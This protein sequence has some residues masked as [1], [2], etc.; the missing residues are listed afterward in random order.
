MKN[1]KQYRVLE[2]FFRGLRGEDISVKKLAE[3]YGVSEKSVSRS[4]GELKAFLADHREL[5]GNTEFEYSY[6]SKCYRLYMDEFLSAKE[7]FALLEVLIGTKSFSKL[8]LLAIVDKLKRF[9]A[10]DDRKKLTELVSKELY[11]YTEVK[12]DCDSVQDMLW[13]LINCIHDKK[14]ITIGYYRMD[15]NFVT[16]RLCPASVMFADH[17]FYLIAFRADSDMSSPLYFRVDR[18]KDITVHREHISACDTPEFDEGLLQQRSLLMWPGKL[19]TIRFEFT[20][21]SV[22]AVLDKLPTAKI[23][24]RDG[25]K[26][27]IEAEVYGDG[28]KMWLL[29][30]GSWAKVVWPEEFVTEMR[31][32]V[33]KL[34]GLY[35]L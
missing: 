10:S 30:Q 16:H 31:G 24:E 15:R 4:I 27:L 13:H 11:H 2:I 35:S 34:A 8:E 29:S 33:Q 6:Q 7:L 17:Y 28:I 1:T 14:E 23:I 20:G 25:S 18:I 3:E 9:T 22:Q 12:H 5:V 26:Y 19:R 21:P 32:E